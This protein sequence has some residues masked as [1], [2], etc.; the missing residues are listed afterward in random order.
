MVLPRTLKGAGALE[1]LLRFDVR[2]LGLQDRA[3]GLGDGGL[4]AGQ[5]RR[6]LGELG[7]QEVARQP[8]QDLALLH[9]V[10]LLGEHLDDAQPLDLGRDQDL[11]ARHQRAGDDGALHD[12]PLDAR[13]TVTT[14]VSSGAAAVL[15]GSATATEEPRST[16]GEALCPAPAVP[17]VTARLSPNAT[18]KPSATSTPKAA[19]CARRERRRFTSGSPRSHS[20]SHRVEARKVESPGESR[21][22]HGQHLSDLALGVEIRRDGAPHEQPVRQGGDQERDR[23]RLDRRRH[24]AA[25][26]RPLDQAREAGRARRNRSRG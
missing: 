16:A 17:G 25:V 5:R 11:V 9:H 12:L 21:L 19:A 22:D 14:G 15:G 2:R 23:L 4:R 6:V 3:L 1:P 18:A 8:G 10:A 20:L 7:L 13:A 24:L 26:L